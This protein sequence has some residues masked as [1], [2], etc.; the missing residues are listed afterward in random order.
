MNQKKS[1]IILVLD[2]SGSMASIKTDMEGG[3]K[4][5]IEKQRLDPGE[6]LVSLFQFDTVYEPVFQTIPVKDVKDIVLVPRGGTALHD[7]VGNTINTVGNRL[8][9]T[10]E[11]DR[12]GLVVFVVITDGEENSS[13][14][15]DG[16]KIKE[17]VKHQTDKYQWQFIFLGAN[18]DAVLSGSSIG[19]KAGSSLS[20]AAN[21][22]GVAASLST[23]SSYV[24][25]SKMAVFDGNG[26]KDIAF[27][28]NDRTA[29]MGGN[30]NTTSVPPAAN[31]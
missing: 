14:E 15:F 28:E 1:E 8:K 22:K 19:M 20:Y 17:M 13:R 2:R 11:A 6:C 9:N 12:P 3:L 24:T 30:S 4:S 26:V 27:D 21:S 25:M 23:V 5:F 10:L 31:P 7:A 16:A 18:Q 29:A